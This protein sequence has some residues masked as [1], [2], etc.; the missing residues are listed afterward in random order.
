MPIIT[1]VKL[2]FKD[3]L[4]Q[5]K[6]STLK[7]RSQVDLIREYKFKNGKIWNGTGIVA[8]NMDHT[9]TFEMAKELASYGL[10]VALHKHYTVEELVEF[11]VDNQDIWDNV[12]YGMG[13]TDQD[14]EKFNKVHL[15]VAEKT[16]RSFFNVC[17][18][19]ANGYSEGFLDFVASF[20]KDVDNSVVMAGNVVTG[21]MTQELILAGVDIVKVGIGPGCFVPGQL[22]R[23]KRGLVPIEEIDYRDEVL[24]HKNRWKRVL[25]TI[26]NEGT[27]HRRTDKDG[28]LV[29]SANPH[30]KIIKV[31]DIKATPN[32]EFYV[33]HKKYQNDVT[34]D[35]IQEYAEWIA[36]ENLTTDYMMV[37]YE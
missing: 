19:V 36:A 7:S 17:I 31:N 16:Q 32:H 24:T 3:V 12:F 35:N 5:P 11:Y 25:T 15:E 23:T 18:D 4:L 26:E 27:A 2:D 13:V 37:K 10:M 8:A 1:D 20:K 6:R 14:Y 28:V 33:I 21:D 9:G 22:V 34:D 29:I 30:S